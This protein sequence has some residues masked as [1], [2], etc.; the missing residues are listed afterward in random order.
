MNKLYEK[1]IKITLLL[2]YFF[3]YSNALADFSGTFTVTSDY[4]W[5]G[6]SKSDRDFA[7]QINFDYEHT[8][9]G[10]LGI[11][12]STVDFADHEFTDR[13]Q[14]EISPYLGW[15]FSFADEW[16]LDLQWTRYFYDGKIFNAYSDY[17]EFYLMLHYRDL[18]TANISFSEDFYHRGH[19]AANFEIDGRYPITD[20]LEFSGTLGYTLAK[21]ALEYDNLYWET[22]LS[23][24]YKFVAFSV[25]YAD[26]IHADTLEFDENDQ[27][28]ETFP[29]VISPTIFFTISIG[30]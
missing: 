2:G 11:F 16:R 17:N 7:F 21:E 1:L 20:W 25:N 28:Q 15:T 19:A 5:R 10:Y 4:I 9:G 8:S 29:E 26:A 23:V 3:L 6:Y 14:F 22:G 27:P 12:A 18:L 30:F 24:Y 13:S